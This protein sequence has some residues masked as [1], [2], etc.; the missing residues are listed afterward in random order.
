MNIRI[1]IA[2]DHPMIIDGLHNMLAGCSHITLTATY[3]NGNQL[4]E[5]LQAET[6]DVLLLDIQ[7]PGKTGDELAP[8]IQKKFPEVRILALTNFDSMLYV[9]NMLRNGVLG[10]LLKT[11]DKQTLV[12]AIETV[13]RGEKFLEQE[14]QEKLNQ[15]TSNMKRDIYSKV[16]LTI[17]EKQI[18]QLVINGHT[19]QKIGEQLFLSLK[20]VENYRSRIFIKLDVKNMAELTKKALALGLA[21]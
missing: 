20:T 6:P 13:Y 14:M 3:S 19:S 9:H 5:G 10:Y 17:R 4:L 11:T 15:Y 21:G 2:D 1:S 12:K 7:L 8:V 18:L 16:S